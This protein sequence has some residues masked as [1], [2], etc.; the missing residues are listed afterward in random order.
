MDYVPGKQLDKIW[1]LLQ[2][3]QKQGIIKQLRTILEAMRS[4]PQASVTKPLSGGPNMNASGRIGSCTDGGIEGGYAGVGIARDCRRISVYESDNVCEGEADFNN[5]IL[6]LVEGTPAPARKALV[7]HLRTDHRVVFTHGDI[8]LHNI[9]VDD[10]GQNIAGLIDW[11]YAGWY[12]E[13]WEYVKFLERQLRTPSD[14]KDCADDI[15][16]Q[17]YHDELVLYQAICRYQMP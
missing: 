2:K 11:E 8:A 16:P 10:H 17:A 9:I 1:H 12:P 5:F 15:F 7:S 13:Y 6:N 14:W 4:I 3:E